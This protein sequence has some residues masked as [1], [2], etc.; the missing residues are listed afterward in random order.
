MKRLACFAVHFGLEWIGYSVRSIRSAVDEIHVFYAPHPSY[1]YATKG[2]VCPEAEEDIRAACERNAGHTPLFWHR[3]TDSRSEGQ[4]KDNML[5]VARERHA[6][7]YILL[8][9]DEVWDTLTAQLTLEHVLQANSNARYQAH[10][11]HF[12][13]SFD[14]T[15]PDPFFPIRVVDMRHWDGPPWSVRTPDR[16]L[17]LGTDEQRK[18]ILHFGYAQSERTMRYKV[19]CHSHKPETDWPA[20]LERVFFP[21]RPGDGA[22][23]LH[24]TTPACWPE[25]HRTPDAIRAQLLEHMGDHPYIGRELIT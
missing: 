16:L 19:T 1:G 17:T 15:I 10:F 13:R 25:L 8:D 6:E 5:R 24:P 4:H 14:W 23:D 18:P 12:W 9:A 20:W 2:A 3:V 11:A 7:A 22:R 21:W